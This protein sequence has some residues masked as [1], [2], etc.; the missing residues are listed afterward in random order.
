MVFQRLPRP[1]TR[2]D[3]PFRVTLRP[4][5]S[6]TVPGTCHRKTVLHRDK[7]YCTFILEYKESLR[8]VVEGPSPSRLR[9]DSFGRIGTDLSVEEDLWGT[10]RSSK[11]WVRIPVMKMEE[12]RN[13]RTGV[14]PTTTTYISIKNQVRTTECGY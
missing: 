5:V 13:Q 2:G 4:T 10:L 7:T 14:Y 11:V 9:D 6:T 1:W 12:T 3:S 8:R